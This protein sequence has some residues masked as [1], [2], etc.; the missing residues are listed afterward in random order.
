[1][2]RDLLKLPDR[3]PDRARAIVELPA[4]GRALMRKLPDGVQLAVEKMPRR[5]LR[6]TVEVLAGFIVLGILAL[7][8]M[9]GR[10]NQGPVSLAF[11]VPMLESAINQEL[12]DIEVKIDD[13]V[14]QKSET[15]A[16]V[17]FR[18]RNI[19][20]VDKQGAVVARSP[21]AAIGLSGR[22]LLSGR[23]TPGSVDFIG[24]RMLLFYT[25]EGGLSLT[26][27]RGQQGAAETG[28]TG[29]QSPAEG[30]VPA[31]VQG[32]QDA[33]A[34]GPSRTIDL[35]KTV[36][37]AFERARGSTTA[38]AYLTRFG[39][40]DAVVVFNSGDR[41]SFWQVPDFA[42]DLSHEDRHSVLLGEAKVLSAKGPWQLNIRTEQSAKHNS[43]T[44]TTLIRDLVPA[45]LASNFPTFKGFQALDLPVTAETS[46]NLTTSGDLLSAETKV[47]LSAGHID[48]PWDRK[49]PML[50][51]EGDLH[52]RYRAHEDRIEVLPSTVQWG[53]SRLTVF[54]EFRP[55]RA[56]ET[57]RT[58]AFRLQA[59]DAVLAA[60]DYAVGPIPVDEWFAEGTVTPGAGFVALSRF[61]ITLGGASLELAG[62]V[63]DAPG[64]PQVKLA[65]SI[66]D[67]PLP[68]LK[69]IWPKL[70]AGGAK[71]W[72]GERVTGGR[73]AEGTVRVN[74]P[75][76][77]LAKLEKGGDVPKEALSVDMDLRDLKI[78]YIEKMPPIETARAR[79]KVRG[80]VFTFDVPSAH[81]ALPSGR[82]LDLS[83]GRFAIDDLRKD[84]QDGV[85]DFKL[86][87]AG[88]GVLEL[89][90][91]Q[92]LEYAKAVGLKPEEIKGKASG[93]FEILLPLLIDLGYEQIRFTGS[94]QLDDVVAPAGFGGASVDG[95]SVTF[96]VNEKAL[97]ARGDVLLN[98]VPALLTWQRLFDAP[99]DKQPAL[100]LTSVLNS[101]ARDKLGFKLNHIIRGPMPI[102]V[103]LWQKAGKGKKIHVQADLANAEVFLSNV[104][105]RKPPGRPAV[106]EFDVATGIEGNRE[107]QNFRIIGSDI[108]IDGWIGL[109]KDNN[110][111]AFYFPDFSLNVITHLELAGTLRDDNV[112]DVQAHGAAYDGRQFFESLFSAGRLA[113][114]QPPAPQESGVDLTAQIKS[115]VGFFDTTVQDVS[116]KMQK[117]GG[118]LTMLSAKGKLD[119]KAPV[120]VELQRPD[121]QSRVLRA[122]TEDAGSAFRLVGFY[123]KIQG[124]EASLQVNLDA[125][126]A[127]K[128]GV[129]WARD[130]VILGDR[131][132]SEVLTSPNDDPLTTFG[133]PGT[134]RQTVRRQQIA[135]DQLRVPFSVGG[136][137]FILH[138]SYI[139]GPQ[140]G[141]TIR[142]NVDFKSQQM[143]LGGTY[144]PLYGLNS[145][146][147]SIPLLGRVFVGRR[148][149]GVLGITFAIQ[150]PTSDPNVLVNPV[151]MV[152]PGIFRQMFEFRGGQNFG[153][154]RPLT[155]T[156]E[157][158]DPLAVP[159]N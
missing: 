128:E 93:D 98:G 132:V 86:A 54:G 32:A 147:G 61:V 68:V 63:R 43:L 51:D 155:G 73:I 133:E 113:E 115:M 100:Q 140:L 76:G 80:R 39:V 12:A 29:A 45:G 145:A 89:L 122:E 22:A 152:A 121:G 34:S 82:R 135:F 125:Q 158:G 159:Q 18:L 119:G 75:A 72:V 42:I 123:P 154:A 81:I 64:S 35:T 92:P 36:T 62:T 101:E 20:L 153:N 70:V 151:S 26:F 28:G 110:P 60:E 103:S 127:D 87:G 88:E 79:L 131:V 46:V 25:P 49:R 104:A 37:A 66:R 137:Q 116:I 148:G 67:M 16:G 96:S 50:I 118:E 24:P 108:A 91:H 141:A 105:W 4:R 149:E 71:E 41:Q 38:S 107:L 59:K 27:S 111:S 21:L 13:A 33:P 112:W 52:V 94:A 6:V 130:F 9:Y 19:R 40:R 47:D 106:L 114:D 90:D 8:L 157:E 15:G 95:G 5:S 134:G 146:L 3:L 55:I 11:L 57:P 120:A 48:V 2:V 56:N 142:G 97:D 144:V 139:N 84:P 10:L 7:A 69:R 109:D 85:I 102:N 126:S 77:V 31:V 53:E 117:R 138:D 14:V 74:M 156:G 23:I 124:G 30:G 78:H 65:G 143:S 99:E 150:G 129:L 136:G 58:W 44:F 83:A 17:L 1:M